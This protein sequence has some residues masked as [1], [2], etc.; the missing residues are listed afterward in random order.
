MHKLYHFPLSPFSRK[1]RLVLAEKKIEAE[2]VEERYWE[3]R[4]QFLQLNPAGQVPVLRTGNIT[5]PESNAIIEYL[6]ETHPEPS[7][8]PSRPEQRAEVRCLNGYFDDAF[9]RDVTLNLLGERVNKKIMSRGSP[10][11]GN[12][13]TGTRRIKYH[14]TRM[15]Q[16]LERRRWL[17]GDRMTLADFAAAAQISCLDYISDVPW[18]QAESVK[19]WYAKIK[20]RPAFRGLL[21]D[22]LPGFPPPPHYSNLDF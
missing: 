18:N 2:L 5:L 4:A 13:R 12:V 19:D 8:M 21:A 6:E 14:L 16:L 3:H 9:Y 20:S 17:A 11:P 7:L 15:E 1:V 22:Q 10:D